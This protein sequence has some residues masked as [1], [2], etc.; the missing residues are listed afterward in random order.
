M[1]LHTPAPPIDP[2]QQRQ[3]DRRRWRRA[4]NLSLAAVL[5]LLAVYSA[6]SAF[7]VNAWTVRPH[8]VAGLRGVL[9][10]PL[11][12]G[13]VDHI[14]SNAIALL[15]LGTL[16]IA[17]YPRALVRTVPLAW[18]GSGLGAWWLG[19]AG[20]SHLGASGVIN[21]LLF[22]VLTLGIVRRDRPAVAAAMLGLT[23][24]GGALMSV[25]PHEPGVSWQSHLGGAVGGVIGGL[26]ARH[27][28]PMPPRVRYSWEDEEDVV[29]DDVDAPIDA[30][31]RDASRISWG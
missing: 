30:P 18:I 1:H 22:M 3:L 16:T 28:D 25:L 24:F 31:H 6:Q 13:S 20:S 2:A 12:H 29:D 7:D 15:L 19:E 4:F 9:T 26:W 27:A 23:L 8:L 10:A 14:A 5:A 17:Q 21:G 11:L